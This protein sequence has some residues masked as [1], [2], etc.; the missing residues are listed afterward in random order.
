MH[1]FFVLYLQTVL[2]LK[3]FSCVAKVLHLLSF[4]YIITNPTTKEN[5]KDNL[6]WVYSK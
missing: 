3:L 5:R 2:F 4:S 1:G 6:S